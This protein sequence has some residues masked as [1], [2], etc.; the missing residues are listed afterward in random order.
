M[1][2]NEAEEAKGV[3]YGRK[4]GLLTIASSAD[5]SLW[6]SYA[7]HIMQVVGKRDTHIRGRGC[8]ACGGSGAYGRGV[9]SGF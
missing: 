5:R 8:G 6:K 9:V 7:A 4:G 1:N 2:H 3:Q